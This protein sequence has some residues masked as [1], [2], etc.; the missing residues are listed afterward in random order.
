VRRKFGILTYCGQKYGSEF[1]KNSSWKVHIEGC[2]ALPN[3]SRFHED[4]SKAGSRGGGTG[5]R[6]VKLKHK[7]LFLST[8]RYQVPVL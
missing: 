1:R 4:R 8:L 6:I 7:I 2:I 3:I 5:P